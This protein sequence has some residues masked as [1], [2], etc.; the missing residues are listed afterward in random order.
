MTIKGFKKEI[1]NKEGRT[2]TILTAVGKT[3][4]E[5]PMYAT[6]SFVKRSGTINLREVPTNFQFDVDE[7][8]TNLSTKVKRYADSLTGEIKEYTS[9]KLYIDDPDINNN[10]FKECSDVF[11]GVRKTGGCFG[12]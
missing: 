8:N 9:I 10:S 7:N 5:C 1:T 3:Q 12:R 4:D 2:A 11:D 6:I